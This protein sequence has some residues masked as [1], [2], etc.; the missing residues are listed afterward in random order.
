M[1]NELSQIYTPVM[2][3]NR[4]ALQFCTETITF[5]RTRTN[6]MQHQHHNYSNNASIFIDFKAFIRTKT[7]YPAAQQYRKLMLI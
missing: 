4:L 7:S 1:L 2:N 3:G 6:S 5:L